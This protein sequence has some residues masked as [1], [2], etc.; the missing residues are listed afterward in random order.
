M[1]SIHSIFV[2]RPKRITDEDGVWESSI[3]RQA[4]IGTVELGPQGI[5]GDQVAD[6][7]HH[8][9][10]SQAVCVHPI[11]HYVY[12]INFFLGPA[13]TRDKPA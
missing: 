1:I 5:V 7:V 2:G 12:G 13:F 9:R 10:P 3:F 6:R 4:V 8:G 11:E